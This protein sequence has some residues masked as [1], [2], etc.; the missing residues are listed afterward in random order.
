MDRLKK[1]AGRFVV[2]FESMLFGIVGFYLI[3]ATAIVCAVAGL[4]IAEWVWPRVRWIETA[5]VIVGIV[6]GGGVGLM[7]YVQVHERLTEEGRSK[8]L[9]LLLSL[10]PGTGLLIGV[11]ELVIR[12]LRG[13]ARS[14]ET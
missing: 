4:M 13:W 12:G 2:E 9:W 3:A 6:A 5:L 11:S 1:G 8:I 7:A 10:I 14:G